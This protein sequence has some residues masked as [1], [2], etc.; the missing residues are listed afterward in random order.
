MM[1]Y[2]YASKLLQYLV[3]FPAALLC[4]LPMKEKCKYSFL[5][6][7][8]LSMAIGLPLILGAS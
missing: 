3:I 2:D 5:R 4:Y 1:I 7:F 8:I 6:I